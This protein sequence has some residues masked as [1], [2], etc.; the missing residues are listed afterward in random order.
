MDIAGP[1]TIRKPRRMSR[2][3]NSRGWLPRRSRSTPSRS[4]AVESPAGMC[5]GLSLRRG[6]AV[7]IKWRLQCRGL[8]VN[9]RNG[10]VITVEN[11]EAIDFPQKLKAKISFGGSFH[12]VAIGNGIRI[13]RTRTR[14]ILAGGS[15]SEGGGDSRRAIVRREV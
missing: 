8:K 7:Q 4:R 3:G 13:I 15:R 14:R 9:D 6:R 11:S 10:Y 2:F 12:E 1:G 5:V